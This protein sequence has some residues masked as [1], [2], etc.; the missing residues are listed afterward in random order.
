MAKAKAKVVAN[1]ESISKTC[2]TCGDMCTKG[3]IFYIKHP[4]LMEAFDPKWIL[5]NGREVGKIAQQLFEGATVL[6]RTD[7]PT[8]AKNT[9]ELIQ[10]G[11]KIICEAAFLADGLFCA[12]DIFRITSGKKCELYEV[13]AATSE[14][15]IFLKDISFQL[16]VLRKAGFTVTKAFLVT[17]NKEFEKQE[18]DIDLSKFFEVT[19]VT[20]KVAELRK[21]TNLEIRRIKSAL[22]SGKEPKTV[23]GEYCFHP[24]KCPF[25]STCKKD[26]PQPTIFDLAGVQ[27]G[28]LLKMYYDEENPVRTMEDFS[29][30]PV[31]KKEGVIL[32]RARQ[33]AQFE[34][35]G[36]DT[37]YI[38][39]NNLVRFMEKL[40]P[41]YSCLDFETTETGVP[42]LK[43][44]KPYDKVAFQASL[45]IVDKFGSQV[46]HLE[47]LA[48]PKTDWRAEMAK[49][50][51]KNLPS[52][53]SVIVYNKS[54]EGSQLDKMATENPK[55]AKKLLSIK[56]R[57]VDLMS[58]FRSHDVYCREF[59]GKYSL[60]VVGPI[61][62]PERINYED[63]EISD[64][65][66]ATMVF[67]RMLSGEMD[68]F[69]MAIAR[70]SLL[71]YCGTDTI[72]PL[73]I[74]NKLI[75]LM[76]KNDVERIF[77]IPDY[78]GE[79]LLFD[80]QVRDSSNVSL[81]HG[82]RV[83][84]DIGEGTVNGHTKCFIRVW[85][86]S[87]KR[88]I[89]RKSYNLV[90]LEGLELPTGDTPATYTVEKFTD[91]IG[92]TA[93][94]GDCVIANNKVGQIIQF[95]DCFVKIKMEGNKLVHKANGNFIIL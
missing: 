49:W 81:K 17:V 25:L 28:T 77:N 6:E 12:V 95:T 18:D 65:T 20:A 11:Q 42:T 66:A 3:S 69:E 89:L 56:D 91:R 83:M 24:Y 31:G 45:H 46:R 48:D 57:I 68:P 43:G 67:S 82:D 87:E 74:I 35:N 84:T 59:K 80:Y 40:E 34:I 86:E 58:V 85:L 51:A 38:D 75:H 94:I 71:K 37:L 29:K 64:G 8:W 62:C 70:R 9:T 63:L 30:M 76:D 33:Q 10:S 41:P 4:E 55:I 36:D 21:Q 19:D 15:D 61:L 5:D 7:K 1:E 23:I 73:W 22:K 32:Q 79:N 90:N 92:R 44:Q 93:C 53:G 60:K 26:L 16:A 54:L 13:K 39:T 72:A 50:I 78:K 88:N 27:V 52:K 2:F 47:Y 14:K